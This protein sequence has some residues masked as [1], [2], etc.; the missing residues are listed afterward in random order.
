ML[1]RPVWHTAGRRLPLPELSRTT[2]SILYARNRPASLLNQRLWTVPGRYATTSTTL[3]AGEDQTGHISAAPNEGLLFFNNVFPIQI[4][5]I[6]GLPIPRLLDKIISPTGSGTDPN[7]I[8][9]RARAK[10]SLPI[11]ATEVLPRMREGGAFVKYTVDDS[12]AA[13]SDSDVEKLLQGYLNDNPVKPW[14]SPFRRVEVSVVKGRPWIEDLMR[15]PTPRL[16]VEFVPAEPGAGVSEAVELSQEQLFELF[17][18]YGKLS[19]IVVQPPDSK[20]LPKFAYLDFAGLP[21]ATMA[22]NCMHGYVLTEA[23]GGGKKG[24][25]VRLKYEAKIKPR[26]FKDWLFS[27]PRIVIPVLAAIVATITVA[28]FDPIRTFF[29]KAHITRTLHFEDNK[30]YKWIKGYA[31]DIFHRRKQED[32]DGMEAIWDDRKGNI[33]Q[34][35]TWLMETADTFIIVQGPRGTGKRELVVDQALQDVKL[36]AV[37]DCK[38]IQEARG[39]SATISAA[40]MAVG[41]KPVFSW[42]NSISG[43]IDMAAQGATGVKTG[44][45]ETL[46]SQLNKIWNTTTTALR[47]IALD[48]RDKDDKDANLGD[49]EWLEAHPERR[50]VVIIDNFLHK[51]QEGGIVYDKIADWAARLTTTNVAHVIFLTNDVSFSKS[52][53]KAL[54]DRV[55]RQISLSDCSPDVAKRFVVKHLDADVEDEPAPKDGSE[56]KLPSRHRTDLGEL[57]TCI[58]Y[59]GGRLTDLEFLARRIKSGETPTKAVHEMIDQSASEILKMYIFGAE[60]EG[61]N[62][63]WNAEQAWFLIKK[64]AKVESIRYNEVML[65]DTLKSGGDNVLRALEQAE[66][67][68]IVSGANGRPSTIKP[69][70]PVYYPAFKRLTEDNVLRSRL[71]LAILTNLTKIESATIDKCE[72]ELLLLSQLRSQPAQTMGRVQYLLDKM[73]VSQ[74]KVEKYEGEMKGLKKV[75]GTEY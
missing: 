27:H 52:L 59:L 48:S 71:D 46:E 55:F 70:K 19:D 29:V 68:T 1:S 50:P 21:N 2:H 26:W 57:D 28:I 74:Q 61:G 75:L 41:Y 15:L 72:N 66:L 62:R 3:Q 24:T 13:S 30:W 5:K 42:M 35:Q 65:D 22:K 23:L 63:N 45:S 43:M 49:D 34:I 44:F 17:R 4:R 14:W 38:P 25:V 54:P 33:E 73:M 6:L 60:D 11:N 40:A 8:L 51:S 16:R 9:E 18:P 69:G 7:V 56:K 37:I 10:G 20:V 39:D 31:T 36:K 53:S 58:D 64:L 67:I 32:D 12:G 47:Q